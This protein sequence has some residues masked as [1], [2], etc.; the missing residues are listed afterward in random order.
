MRIPETISLPDIPKEFSSEWALQFRRQVEQ[1]YA[2]ISR[3][4]NGGGGLGDGVDIDNFMGKWLTYTTNGVANTEDA[5]T[6]DLGVTPI[7]FLVVNPPASGF[8][9]RG[10]TSW[11]ASKIYLKCSAASQTALILVLIPSHG[12]TV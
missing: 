5:V 9:Y 8:V 4:I 2:S 7:G 11:T 12:I 3:V 1:A 6:H 10:A